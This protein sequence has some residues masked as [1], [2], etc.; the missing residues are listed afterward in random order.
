MKYLL[1]VLIRL[2]WLVPS[3]SRNRCLFKEFC[4]RHVFRVTS[5][6]G[7]KAG[8]KALKFRFR[9][10]RPTYKLL[11]VGR[12]SVLLCK[13]G[14]LIDAANMANWLKKKEQEVDLEK[15]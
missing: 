11:A 9:T 10:F 2:Y 1:L 6:N 8:I 7:F 3:K 15:L 13:N 4:C 14:H 12:Q 5:T